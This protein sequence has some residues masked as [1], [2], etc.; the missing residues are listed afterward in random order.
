MLCPECR[1]EMLVLEYDNVEIDFCN[2]CHGI[3]LDEGELELLLDNPDDVD[4]PILKALVDKNQNTKK[5]GR[6]CPVCAKPMFLVYIPLSEEPDSKLVEI[7]KCRRNHGLWFDNGELQ[8][9][10]TAANNGPVTGFLSDIF[11]GSK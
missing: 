2:T 8:E 11:G 7:D 4:S 9:I 10:L 6:K 3:W 1:E 5:D